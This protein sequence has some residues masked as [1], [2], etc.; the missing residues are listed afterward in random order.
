MAFHPHT[1][2]Q[3]LSRGTHPRMRCPE[4]SAGSPLSCSPLCP[5]LSTSRVPAYCPTERFLPMVFLNTLAC[6]GP[7]CLHSVLLSCIFKAIVLRDPSP[8]CPS[9][10][11]IPFAHLGGHFSSRLSPLQSITA[12]HS[13]SP[14]DKHRAALWIPRHCTRL[15]PFLL[16]LLNKSVK[17]VSA[18]GPQ[19]G[20]APGAQCTPSEVSLP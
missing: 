11:N 12:R 20:V 19:A 7:Q 15:L 14:D 10:L 8:P 9:K 5:T 4:T 18:G 3:L 17:P 16:W 2:S 1:Q 6:C 13:S